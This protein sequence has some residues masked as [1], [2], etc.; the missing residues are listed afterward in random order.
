MCGDNIKKNN[1]ELKNNRTKKINDILKKII[2]D[3]KPDKEEIASINAA[4]NEI[5]I[6]L[7][8]VVNKDIEILLTGSVA[9]GTNVRG[10][11]DIDI[12]LLFTKIMEEREME[13]Q[14]LEIAKKIV[15]KNKNEKY[16]IKYTEHP[17]TMLLMN[18]RAITVDLVPSFKITNASERISAVDRTQLHNQFINSNFNQKLRDDVRVLKT[19]LAANNIYGAESRIE[20]FSGYLCELLIFSAGSFLNLLQQISKIKLPKVIDIER[21]NLNT[22]N[23]SENQIKK[24]DKNFIVIDPVDENRNVAANVSEESLSTFILKAREFL[25]APNINKFYSSK[26][27]DLNTKARIKE[28]KNELNIDIY[29]IAF[30]VPDIA[31][32]IIWQQIKKLRKKIYEILKKNNFNCEISFQNISLQFGIICFFINNIEYNSKTIIG[33]NILMEESVNAF[34][35]KHQKYIFIKENKICSIQ[36]QKYKYPKEVFEEIVNK[37]IIKFPSYLDKQ[38]IKLYINNI[39]EIYAKLLNEIIKIKFLDKK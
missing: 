19:F 34:I 24:F 13:K 22:N 37:K 39:P 32:D 23:K 4:V 12:F 8:K 27:S 3:V 10:K 6:R 9:R 30:K 17:Y 1:L 18:D 26:Y 28:L 31:E 16:I 5:M 21:K 35:N 38:N 14:G 33:P 15:D 2:H 11:Y 29:L 7:K 25:K 36:K 20:G